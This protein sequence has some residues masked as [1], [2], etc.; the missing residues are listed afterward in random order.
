MGWFALELEAE[1]RP[2]V[3]F[4][5]VGGR[6]FCC[7]WEEEDWDWDLVGDEEGEGR[8]PVRNRSERAV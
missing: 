7:C 8:A 2:V 3:L 1:V 4:V 5:E 6:S